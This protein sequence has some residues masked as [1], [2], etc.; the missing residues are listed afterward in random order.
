MESLDSRP[1]VARSTELISYSFFNWSYEEEREQIL[2][3]C[4]PLFIDSRPIK[5]SRD[6]KMEDSQDPR[7][8][9]TFLT[10]TCC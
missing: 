6:E 7:F 4:E 10:V 9:Q 5:G 2:A 8:F 1:V 3:H